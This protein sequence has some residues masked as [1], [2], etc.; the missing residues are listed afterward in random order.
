MKQEMYWQWQSDVLTAQ[1]AS[2]RLCWGMP[3]QNTKGKRNERS[4]EKEA[5][6]MV[7]GYISHTV[8]TAF[9]NQGT[10]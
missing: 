7:E 10:V 2:E 4:M 6:P 5:R 9:K 8:S 1:K 3:A